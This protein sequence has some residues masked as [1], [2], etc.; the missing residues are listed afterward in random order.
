VCSQRSE[1]GWNE[2]LQAFRRDK[3]FIMVV[4]L[5]YRADFLSKVQL[6]I[7]VR[8][9]I[10]RRDVW[11]PIS[12]NGAGGVFN[13]PPRSRGGLPPRNDGSQLSMVGISSRQSLHV[14]GIAVV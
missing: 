8:V 2:A 10:F 9:W 5:R 11:R 6:S 4:A 3:H 7:V 12:L 14:T 13:A 1:A